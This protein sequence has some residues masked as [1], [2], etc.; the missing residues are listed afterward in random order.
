MV[1]GHTEISLK[2]LKGMWDQLAVCV[3]KGEYREALNYI[4]FNEASEGIVAT[5][6]HVLMVIPNP[7][8]SGD[9]LVP[10]LSS[11]FK[12]IRA[13]KDDMV[14]VCFAKDYAMFEAKGFTI[15]TG[16]ADNEYPPYRRVL[17]SEK[18][19]QAPISIAPEDIKTAKSVIQSVSRSNTSAGLWFKDGMVEIY[20][21]SAEEVSIEVP[22]EGP[23]PEFDGGYSYIGFN[24]NCLHDMV[25]HMDGAQI[26]L[27]KD[28]NSVTLIKGTNDSGVIMPIKINRPPSHL[29]SAQQDKEGGQKCS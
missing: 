27:N 14:Q 25:K 19:L 28:M 3:A 2:K 11:V 23:K 1:K 12:S 24:I 10:N 16:F 4:Y 22:Y 29:E 13:K 6:G 5:N 7:F 8:P 9:V 20:N 17:P 21:Q 15:V 26:F 18:D